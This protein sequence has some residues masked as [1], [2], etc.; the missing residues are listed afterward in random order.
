MALN[1]E[2]QPNIIIEPNNYSRD[3]LGLLI[4]QNNFKKI[5]HLEH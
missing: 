5:L 1:N 2:G 4:R 3:E